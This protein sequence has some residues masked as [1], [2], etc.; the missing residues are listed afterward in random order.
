MGDRPRI[1]AFPF[2]RFAMVTCALRMLASAAQLLALDVTRGQ[3]HCPDQGAAERAGNWNPR[4][5]PERVRG[6]AE[7]DQRHASYG[8]ADP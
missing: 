4:E 5:S 6:R 1:G 3:E 2:F 7:C 8:A